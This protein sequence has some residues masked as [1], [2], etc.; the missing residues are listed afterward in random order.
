MRLNDKRQFEDKA[1]LVRMLSMRRSGYATSSLAIIF[2]VDR[3]SIE[4]QCNKYQIVPD[5]EVY[6]LERI[7]T[8][9]LNFLI[10]APQ[11]SQWK[12]VNGERINLGRDYRDY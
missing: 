11:V 1:K 9:V 4:Y 2:A 3:S 12:T 6:A 10:P 7:I 5:Q 8:S